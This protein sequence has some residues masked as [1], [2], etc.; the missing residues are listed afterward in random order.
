MHTDFQPI[1]IIGA[2]R[3]GTKLVRELIAEHP[4]IARVPYDINYTWRL[5]NDHLAHD[6]LTPSHLTT[7]VVNRLQSSIG[8]Y[9][10]GTPFLVEKTVSNCLR[11]PFVHAV[12]PNA[13]FVHLLRDGVHVVE[14]VY[15]EWTASPDWRY[16]L[17][18]VRAFPFTE[19]FGYATRYAAAVARKIIATG[20]H[21]RSTW[22][23]RYQ[24]IDDDLARRSLLEVCAIQWLRCVESATTALQ[25]LPEDQVYTIRYEAFLQTS[26]RHLEVLGRFLGLDTAPYAT[27]NGLSTI[28]T[29]DIGKGRHSLTSADHELI[30]PYLKK[31]ASLLQ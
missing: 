3:S 21:K 16:I 11:V 20:D 2:A 14:S 31:G 9:V 29:H 24:G 19:S 25:A 30:A 15:R 7:E 10:Q 22:G 12:Y 28:L 6:E 23:P 13:R 18:K 5:G 17:A 27:A 8:R 4:A 26:K 1:I